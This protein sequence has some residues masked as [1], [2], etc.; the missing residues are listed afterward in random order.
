M[1]I[2]GAAC[3]LAGWWSGHVSSAASPVAAASN[4]GQPAPHTLFASGPVIAIAPDGKATLH[5][6]GEPLSWV[7]AEIDRQSGAHA[8]AEPAAARG[9]AREAAP[10]AVASARPED[11]AA[12]VM[13]GSE[14]E[15]YDTLVQSRSGGAVSED[16]LKTLYQTDDSPRVRL[17]AFDYAQEASEGDP[18]ARRAELEAARLLP[19][20]VVAQEAGRR[21]DAMDAQAHRAA[22]QVAAQR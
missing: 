3:G 8:P 17:L 14:A 2:V 11:V 7:L 4:A 16:M 1:L 22:Q 6:D 21:L 5:V 12:R 18:A 13:R 20:A 10:V 19:D 9:A 15:R